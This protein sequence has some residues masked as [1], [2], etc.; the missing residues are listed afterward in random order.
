MSETVEFAVEQYGASL[1]RVD[2]RGNPITNAGVVSATGFLWNGTDVGALVLAALPSNTW[3]AAPS[4][5]NYMPRTEQI[6]TNAVLQ[7][8]L[9]ARVLTNDVRYLASLTNAAA[10]ATAAQGTRADMALTNLNFGVDGTAAYRGD[11]GQAASNL[12]YATSIGKVDKTDA[13]YLASLTNAAAFA[14]A[15]QGAKADM[16]LTNQLIFGVD[17]TTVYRGDW[18]QAASN[19]AY[20]TS[21]GK[22]DKSDP[23][24]SRTSHGHGLLTAD[25]RLGGSAGLLVQ[26]TTA[27]LLSTKP[28]GTTQQ[29]LRGDGQWATAPTVGWQ[30]PAAVSYWTYSLVPWGSEPTGNTDWAN[31]VV[32]MLQAYT[33]PP[34]VVIPDFIDGYP[35]A[36]LQ[37]GW[38][39]YETVFTEPGSILTITAGRNLDYI[40]AFAL[41]GLTNLYRLDTPG[42]TRLGEGAISGC[43]ALETLHFPNTL[44]YLEGQ[45]LYDLPNLQAVYWGGDLPLGGNNPFGGST[46]QAVNYVTNPTAT[47]WGAMLGTRPVVRLEATV[48]ALTLGG[49]RRVEWPGHYWPSQTATYKAYKFPAGDYLFGDGNNLFYVTAAGVTNPITSNP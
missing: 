14:T 45:S 12:A 2:L 47:G 33:G 35:V 5:T 19:L 30:N 43:T 23:T 28:A 42:L 18:G 11:W 21:I 20:A 16:A 26:T 31:R 48:G 7:S 6:L 3:A 32:V 49:V 34:D 29:W 13:R 22:V 39:S 36:I 9:N 17:G 4:T 41:S 38:G 25:G 27:G 1:W 44:T 10:F 40:G 46:T 8:G 24:Y 15:E 37:S